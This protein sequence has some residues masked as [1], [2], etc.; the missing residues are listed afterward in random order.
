V[1]IITISSRAEWMGIRERRRER[2]E[3]IFHSA[4]AV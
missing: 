4:L 2:W 3:C 1:Y